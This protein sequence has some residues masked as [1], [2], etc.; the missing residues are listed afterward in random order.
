MELR[1]DK[2]LSSCLSWQRNLEPIAADHSQRQRRHPKTQ[3][4]R[5]LEGI[6]KIFRTSTRRQWHLE[7]ARLLRLKKAARSTQ[8]PRTRAS[9]THTDYLPGNM[10]STSHGFLL[11]ST[12]Y[13]EDHSPCVSEDNLQEL[14]MSFP[15]SIMWLPETELR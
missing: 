13:G 10:L 8:H 9:K 3:G 15:P 1:S 5:E 12:C 14:L 11:I 6:V 7:N 2:C 4:L